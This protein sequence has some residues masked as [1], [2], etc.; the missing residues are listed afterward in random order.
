[1][2]LIDPALQKNAVIGGALAGAVMSVATAG[3]SGHRDKVIKDAIDGAAIAAAAEFI[4][5]RVRVDL[6]PVRFA[7]GTRSRSRSNQTMME[8]RNGAEPWQR[9]EVVDPWVAGRE[10]ELPLQFRTDPALS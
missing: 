1:M 5:H 3:R 9:Q 7:G 8:G 2:F 6:G 4:G 10:V